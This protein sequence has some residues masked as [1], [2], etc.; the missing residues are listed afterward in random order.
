MAKKRHYNNNSNKKRP[1][2][3]AHAAAVAA[4]EKK[5]YEKK[6]VPQYGPPF[7]LLEDESKNTFE[8][9]R[10]AWIAYGSTIAECR[11]DCLV[12]ELA[13]KVNKMTRYEVRRQLPV[14]V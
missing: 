2:R 5:P 14:G 8:Y 1:V 4:P 7:V 12:Q 13:Q 10:G 9:R 6:P 3:A 11:V